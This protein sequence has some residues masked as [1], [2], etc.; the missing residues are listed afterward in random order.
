MKCPNCGA[1]VLKDD[2]TCKKCGHVLVE[3]K[4]AYSAGEQYRSRFTLL[5][6]T[7]IGA[8]FGFHLKWLGYDAKAEEVR[9]NYMPGLSIFIQPW[10]ILFGI[11]WQLE[12][13]IGVMFGKYREDRQGHPV[14]YFQPK[15]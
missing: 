7:W 13:V 12:E 5:F 6:R 9:K 10:K 2:Q 14:R 11:F 8:C 4:E 3:A 1:T 15:K